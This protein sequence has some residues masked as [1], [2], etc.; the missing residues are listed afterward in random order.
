MSLTI[1]SM[2]TILFISTLILPFSVLAEIHKECLT[3]AVEV[4]LA[5]KISKTSNG[6]C[7]YMTRQNFMEIGQERLDKRRFLKNAIKALDAGGTIPSRLFSPLEHTGV[8]QDLDKT[9][10]CDIVKV[11]SKMAAKEMMK[12]CPDGAELFQYILGKQQ[13]TERISD[14]ELSTACHKIEEL[15][16]EACKGSKIVYN[17][18]SAEKVKVDSKSSASMAIGQ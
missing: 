14:V 18:D 1:L 4:A 15:K 2:K 12:D 5:Y 7:S 6:D 3:E 11:R 8:D 13:E 9:K 10:I 16:A 17:L